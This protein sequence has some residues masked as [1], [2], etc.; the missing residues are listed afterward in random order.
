MFLSDQPLHEKLVQI[1]HKYLVA[2]THEFFFSSASVYK[3]MFK[4]TNLE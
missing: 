3:N 2:K 1:L 4:A